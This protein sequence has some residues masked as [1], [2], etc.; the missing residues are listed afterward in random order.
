MFVALATQTA[1]AHGAYLVQPVEMVEGLATAAFASSLP[2]LIWCVKNRVR[3]GAHNGR[4]CLFSSYV[5]EKLGLHSSVSYFTVHTSLRQGW[6]CAHRFVQDE[7][8]KLSF[9]S[10]CLQHALHRSS[11]LHYSSHSCVS[12]KRLSPPVTLL[13]YTPMAPLHWPLIMVRPPGFTAAS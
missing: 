6:S 4:T 13:P 11:V 2:A 3:S 1:L 7:I 9:P 5:H 10:K 12:I 8:Q